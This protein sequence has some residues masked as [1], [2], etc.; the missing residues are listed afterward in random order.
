MSIPKNITREHLLSAIA[1]IDQNGFRKEAESTKY[2]VVFKGKKYPP[3]LVVSIANRYANGTEL[4]RE[5]FSGGSMSNDFLKQFDFRIEDKTS[6]S[7]RH[8]MDFFTNEEFD[9]LEETAEKPCDRSQPEVEKAYQDLKVAYNKVKYWAE[10]LQKKMF[11]NGKVKITRRPTSQG[12]RF[13]GYLWGRIYPTE[14]DYKDKW[15]ALTVGMDRSYRYVIKIDTVLLDEKTVTRKKYEI[16]RGDYENSEIVIQHLQLKFSN[17]NGLLEQ[18]EKDL[19]RLMLHFPK[20]KALRKSIEFSN[21][22]NT[23]TLKPMQ[24]TSPLNQILYGPPGTG[25]TY[26]TKQLAVEIA[27]P[28]FSYDVQSGLLYR[29]Q[30]NSSYNNLVKS[31]QVV[32]TTFHQSFGYEDFVEGIKPF[33]EDGIVKYEVKRGIFK[34][35]CLKAEKT[36]LAS[37]FDEVYQRYIEDV[38]EEVDFVL[39]TPS[40]KRPFSVVVSNNQNSIAVP[41]TEKATRMTISKDMIRDYVDSGKIGEWQSYIVAIGEHIKTK[42][43]LDIISDN[44]LKRNYVLIIDEINRGNVSSIFGELITLL[45]PDKR[46]GSKEAIELKLPYSKEPFTVPSNVYLIGTM[47]TADRSVEAI[48]TAL[49]RRFSF[50]E[51]MPKPQMISPAYAYWDL[52]WEYK[53]KEWEDEEYKAKEKSLFK[54]IGADDDLVNSRKEI[55]ERMK[56]EGRNINQTSFF[57]EFQYNGIR[58]DLVLKN[59]NRRI[60][61]LLDR[62]HS[63]GHSYFMKVYRS[64]DKIGKLKEVFRNKIIPLLQEYFFGNYSKI[65][66]VLGEAFVNVEEIPASKIFADSDKFEAIDLEVKYTLKP[67]DEI[68]FENSINAL[69]EYAKD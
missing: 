67:F 36:S 14:Q 23:E 40:Q 21:S 37:N 62:D 34:E 17:W 53:D 31:G 30:L 61:A 4:P 7:K 33:V 41:H 42:Y 12:N 20:I 47:N 35:L 16:A 58:L 5:S 49:R 29:E 48:D 55:W 68:D 9:L 44:N 24:T 2:D 28:D 8:T 43:G 26:A 11:S 39:H 64:E 65:G 56:E 46:S 3:K 32:F 59:I 57:E 38:S 10:E 27:N 13:D 25:K 60:E 66:L 63:I 54:F 15:L 52:L 69:K 22:H 1:E 18:S 51:V 19:E 6:T 45:E 50:T